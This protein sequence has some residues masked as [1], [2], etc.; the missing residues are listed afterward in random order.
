[1]FLPTNFSVPLAECQRVEPKKKEFYFSQTE[2][3]SNSDLS[4][5]KAKME[6]K[7]YITPP[8]KVFEF[9]SAFDTLCT[10]RDS[11]KKNN[12]QL[13]PHQFE[14]LEA[15]CITLY[16]NYKYIF[17]NCLFQ[18]EYY[19]DEI[20]SPV[21]YHKAKCKVDVEVKRKGIKQ[22]YDIKTTTAKTLSEFEKKMTLYAYDRAG[23][24]YHDITKASHYS[25]LVC[26]YTNKPEELADFGT[27]NMENRLY[28][29]YAQGRT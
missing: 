21:G 29:L 9:G 26:N 1:M 14:Q 19:C 3:L 23:A 17:E 12:Y 25:L 11:F 18:K 27:P 7:N 24:W 5:W 22:V 20:Y 28:T 15:M 6:G 8:Q 13:K 4:Y 2:Y 10:E 16:Y